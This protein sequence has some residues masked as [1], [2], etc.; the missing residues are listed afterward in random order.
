M[1]IFNAR[2][3]LAFPGGD[4]TTDTLIGGVHFNKTTL[5]YWNYTLYS[6][7]TL[8]N[9]SWCLL[10]FEPYSPT[11]LFPN[12]T[13]LNATWCFTPLRPM[14]PRATTGVGF[15]VA[16]CLVLLLVLANLRKHGRLYLPAE[17][18]FRPIG[19]RW[20]W[21]WA[22]ITCAAALISLFTNVDVDRYWVMELPIVLTVFFWFLMQLATMAMVWEAV[23]HW[24][25]WKE[26]QFVD[27]D[28]FALRQDDRRAKFEFFAPLWFYLWWWLV[29]LRFPF[30]NF[31]MCMALTGR[32]LQN[33]FMVIPRNWEPIELQRSPD[34]ALAL[35][36]PA[37]TEIRFK[38]GAFMLFVCW[39]T[40]TVHLWHSIHHYNHRSRG[41]FRRTVSCIRYIPPRFVVIVPAALALVA[42]Q[43]LSSFVFAWSPLNATGNLAA[44][45]AGGYGPSLLILCVQCV[46][47]F[48]TPNEDR[49][50]IRQRQVRGQTIDRELGIVKKPAW[51][52]RVNGENIGNLRDRIARNVK[53]I[54]GGRA[55]AQGVDRNIENQ[56]RDANNSTN[57]GGIE[58]GAIRKTDTNQGAIKAVSRRLPQATPYVGRSE[59]RRSER[60]MQTAATL[61]FPN[62]EGT[63]PRDRAAELMLDGP[64]PPYN[65]PA[66]ERGRTLNVPESDSRSRPG[67][68]ERSNSTGTLV[69]LSGPPQQIRSM[70]DI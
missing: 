8:S 56:A 27:P 22:I 3:L 36:A 68:S 65:A 57:E 47:G 26:R 25:S 66:A 62:A 41:V 20:Q 42:Y 60:T 2:D 55:T 14:G 1:P 48:A 38:V 35:A 28:P 44:I 43:A 13:F 34:Q 29:S 10:V 12:G 63:G 51:W 61:L 16:F 9:G 67:T 58:M 37:A 53:E 52:K 46:H 70:L 21:Y 69:S 59:A 24:G 6:N 18:R 30:G 54:G 5:E 23:R 50:L 64:P 19:R 39:L 49:E 32:N 40:T 33:F 15:A 31:G 17:T 4:N 45:Y 11:L 7:N